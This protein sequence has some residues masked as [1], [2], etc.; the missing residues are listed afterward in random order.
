MDHLK[1]HLIDCY[2]GSSEVIPILIKNLSA[3]PVNA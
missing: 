3:T 1:E 2:N